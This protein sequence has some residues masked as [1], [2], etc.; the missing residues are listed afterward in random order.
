MTKMCFQHFQIFKMK[1]LHL[2]LIG[3]IYHLCLFISLKCVEK[4]CRLSH[5]ILFHIVTWCYFISENEI[6]LLS[7]SKNS[8]RGFEP[9]TYYLK[10]H[11]ITTNVQLLFATNSNLKYYILL[12]FFPKK[13][14]ISLS[15]LTNKIL[16][17]I[18]SL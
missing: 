2:M 3:K 4:S 9:M 7:V 13:L 16:V 1:K 5:V 6:S 14:P 10:C 11:D 17:P 12:T 8:I 15:E 18:L